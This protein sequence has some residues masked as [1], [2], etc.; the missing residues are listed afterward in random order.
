MTE[1][2]APARRKRGSIRRMGASLQ[3]RVSAGADPSHGERSA[4]VE[5]VLIEKHMI[6]GRHD[7]GVVKCQVHVCKPYAASSIRQIHAILSGA[8][9]AAVRWGWIPYNPMPSVKP[10]AKKRPHPRPPSPEQMARIVEAA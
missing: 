4:L 5:G 9:S 7:C 1:A 8:L 3:V 10:P 2:E 6:D